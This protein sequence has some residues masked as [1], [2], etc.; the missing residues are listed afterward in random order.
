MLFLFSR[1]FAEPQRLGHAVARDRE[2][3]AAFGPWDAAQEPG[4]QGGPVRGF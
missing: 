4:L 2:V 3:G 1:N